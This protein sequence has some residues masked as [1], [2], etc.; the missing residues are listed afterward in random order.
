MA[1]LNLVFLDKLASIDATTEDDDNARYLYDADR[2]LVRAL[3]LANRRL[4]VLATLMVALI[5][6]VIIGPTP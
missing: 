2:Q 5:L 4:I 1:G 3:D 6:L